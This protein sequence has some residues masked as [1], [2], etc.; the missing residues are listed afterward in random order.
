MSHF[1]LKCY[2]KIHVNTHLRNSSP[3]K[4]KLHICS[5]A[6]SASFLLFRCV[7]V[8]WLYRCLPSLYY[9]III[10]AFTVTAGVRNCS[11]KVRFSFVLQERH[12]FILTIIFKLNIVLNFKQLHCFILFPSLVI[13]LFSSTVGKLLFDQI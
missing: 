13:V 4:L 10:I 2:Q 6:C 1:L 12:N 5:H 3:P 8:Y 9:I 7:V 11:A